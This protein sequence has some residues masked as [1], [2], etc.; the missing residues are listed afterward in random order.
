[1]YAFMRAGCAFAFPIIHLSVPTL[2][3]FDTLVDL[4]AQKPAAIY[5]TF[6]SH[7]FVV[8]HVWYV[9]VGGGGRGEVQVLGQ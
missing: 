1:M 6:A 5:H 8:C 2:F 9:G 4:S 7:I 3:Y